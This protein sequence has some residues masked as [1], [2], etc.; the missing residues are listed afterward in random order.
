M[1]AHAFRAGAL[2]ATISS[3]IARS[4]VTNSASNV[5][6]KTYDYIVVGGGLAGLTVANRLSEN[7]GTTVL[8]IEAGNDDRTDPRVY[9]I[10]QY[11]VAF[12]SSL[13][14]SYPTDAGKS[15]RAG[16][17]LGGGTSINGAAYTRGTKEQYDSWSQLL[18]PADQSLGWNWDGLFSYMK[19]SEGFSAP[20]SQQQAKGANSIASYHG[21]TGPVQVTFPDLMYGGP[22]QPAFAQTM[23]NMGLVKYKDLNGGTPNCVS[24]TPNTI[25]WHDNDHR[26]SSATAYINPVE[27]SRPNWTVLTGQQVTKILFS[28]TSNSAGLKVATGVQ[29]GTSSGARYIANARKEVIV[30]AGAIGSPALLQLS[31]IGSPSLLSKYGIP[32]VVNLPQVGLNLQ[33]QTI[34]SMGA[35]GTNFN[36]GGS[37]PS[38]VIAY[39]NIYQL[40]GSGASS[41]VSHIKSSISTW[42]SQQSS[43]AIS[44]SAL[45]TIY[46]I[47]AGLI[48][49][50]NAPVAELF[51]DNGYPDKIGTDTWQLL[52]F[53]RGN[54][55]I[56]S[57]NPFT[58]PKTNVNYFSADIDLTMQ[59]QI[60]RFT[61]QA[62]LTSP[63][64][65][66]SKG[67]THPGFSTV[68]GSTASSSY[69]STSAWT[70]WIKAH[71]SPVSHPIATCAMM[72]KSLGGVVDGK[73]RVYGTANVR[74]VDASVM[75]M[76]VSAHLSATLYGIAEK[77]ADLIKSGV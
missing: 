73:L 41:I 18:D 53:S 33:E 40:F 28:S 9:D 10:Y 47:Q 68:P 51:F 31:G 27:S 13:D 35:A 23:V 56:T 46:N 36:A 6:N 2:L 30:A 29:F 8:V 62:Y 75:P 4:V 14:W 16:K 5:S 15:I 65:T 63:L 39:P 34:V 21:T 32:V 72:S 74:V 59:I 11:T 67:E 48:I 58:K 55:S 7:A 44:A 70:S 43:S 12:F 45:Q 77:A 71:F 26:S 19:K 61:R 3:V 66:Y 37:G 25:N 60:Q 76:Q 50:N 38:D 20:N 54:V 69:G 24:F 49:N 57:S 52:P 42:A 17:T 22:Q 64:K 1:L